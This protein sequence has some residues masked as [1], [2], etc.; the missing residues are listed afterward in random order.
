MTYD[1]R[2]YLHL[3]TPHPRH[4]VAIFKIIFPCSDFTINVVD[5]EDTNN[6]SK[7]KG[8]TAPILSVALD[9]QGEYL[10][11]CVTIQRFMF[12]Q[13]YWQKCMYVT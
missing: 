1:L 10:V 9:P 13:W 6:V 5:I 12:S 3:F 8:H 2:V 7:F 4:K 11:S